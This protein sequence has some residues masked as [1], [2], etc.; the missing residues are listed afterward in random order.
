LVKTFP[1]FYGNRR[2]IIVFKKAR[3]IPLSPI[4]QLSY[5]N[6]K[7]LERSMKIRVPYKVENLVSERL[8]A[9]QEELGYF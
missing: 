3:H 1:A 9:S 5:M 7:Y 6:T 8:L 4:T 2:F